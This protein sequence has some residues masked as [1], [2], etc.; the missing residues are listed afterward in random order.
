[1]G[2]APWVR[3]PHPPGSC[4]STV[5]PGWHSAR[6]TARIGLRTGMWLDVGVV[7]AEQ[8]LARS[9]ASCS[10]LSTYLQPP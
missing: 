10:A 2:L 6:Y 1:M 4:P 7:G 5:S 9:I 8:L 3:C